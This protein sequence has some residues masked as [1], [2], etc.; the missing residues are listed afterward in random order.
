MSLLSWLLEHF[1]YF[2]PAVAD[3]RGEGGGGGESRV[4]PSE[5]KYEYIISV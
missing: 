1:G 4:P 5:P 3:P 2:T